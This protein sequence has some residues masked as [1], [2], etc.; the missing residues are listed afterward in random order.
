MDFGFFIRNLGY[1][2]NLQLALLDDFCNLIWPGLKK[3]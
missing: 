3:D 1:I 2:F